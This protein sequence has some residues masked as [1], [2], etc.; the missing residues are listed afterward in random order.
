M[1][2]PCELHPEL[3]TMLGRAIRRQRLLRDLKQSYVA[4]RVG[5]TQ[6]S[7]SR[8]ESGATDPSW[9]TVVAIARAIGCRVRDFEE[10]ERGDGE[11]GMGA[12]RV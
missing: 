2:W 10:E 11:A 4:M 9:S 3:S 6:G 8:I 12:V 1:E 5:I 7:Y